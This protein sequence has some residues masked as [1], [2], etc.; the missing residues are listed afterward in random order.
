VWAV[1]ARQWALVDEANKQLSDQSVEMA[2]LRVAYAAVKE[3]AV[4]EKALRPARGR[5]FYISL[6]R[7][8][9]VGVTSLRERAAS[10]SLRGRKK[11]TKMIA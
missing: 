2:E 10:P 5:E 4:Q 6:H 8:A 11:S 9:G 3:E 1:L 7:G